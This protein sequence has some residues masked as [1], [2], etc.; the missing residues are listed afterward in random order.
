MAD[1]YADARDM[2]D[3]R[4]AKRAA[5]ISARKA[6][7]CRLVPRIAEIEKQLDATGMKMLS[8]VAEDNVSPEEAAERIMKQN[9]AFCAERA[10]LLE[11]NGFSPDFLEP[12]FVCGKCSDT[13]YTKDGKRCTCVVKA[14]TESALRGANLTKILRSQTF[15]NFNL[16]YYDRE[17]NPQKGISPRDNA[18]SIKA[19]AMDF[20]KK[21]D[22]SNENL[23]LYGPSGLGKTFIS[24]AIASSLT[25]AGR[26]VVYISANVLFP[27]LEDIHFCRDISER[28]RYLAKHAADCELLVL[29]DVGAEFVTPFTSAEF[30]RIINTRLLSEKK[31]V[32][33][34]NL[35]YAEIPK[36]YSERI[37]S[38][39]IGSFTAIEFFGEDIRQKIKEE[40]H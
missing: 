27:I 28:S 14:V 2:L 9:R 19:A 31:M 20:V 38:R 21:F 24:S 36:I 23:W 11:E 10:K 33:S 18:R 16:T 37:V 22:V 32:F 8:A 30:F 34:S 7:V 39:L 4:R 6:E 40:N 35:S 3:T 26:D 5:L 25:A 29:D 13:G 15:E 17:I 12:K 1:F